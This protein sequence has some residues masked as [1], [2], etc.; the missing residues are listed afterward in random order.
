MPAVG[1]IYLML[2]PSMQAMRCG[3]CGRSM[4]V[5][6]YTKFAQRVAAATLRAAAGLP[7]GQRPPLEALLR[8][9]DAKPLRT[10]D[11]R[12]ARPR[13][14]CLAGQA[15]SLRYFSCLSWQL[16]HDLTG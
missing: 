6:H 12:Q 14:P 3:R 7:P 8:A 5:A 15:V 16:R 4:A 10:C 1:I 9:A 13:P 11:P 2:A